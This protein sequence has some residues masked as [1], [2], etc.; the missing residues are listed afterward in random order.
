MKIWNR[1]TLLAATAALA[2]TVAS[3]AG[4]VALAQEPVDDRTLDRFVTAFLDVRDIQAE[5]AERLGSV[6]DREQAQSLQSEAQDE[7]IAAVED[8]GLSVQEYNQVATMMQED[9]EL[10]ERV[11]EAAEAAMQ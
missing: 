9:P 11:T 1:K 7:M 4:T 5:F 3:A 2:L 6:E 10:R 8:A